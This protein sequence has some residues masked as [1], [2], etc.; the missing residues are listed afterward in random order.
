MHTT[1]RY[2]LVINQSWQQVSINCTVRPLT[3]R[4][5]PHN[6]RIYIAVSLKLA[7][8]YG[9]VLVPPVKKRNISATCEKKE[10]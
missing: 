3:H 7:V 10:K 9:G 6:V 4:N 8:N 2:F 5:F 1:N